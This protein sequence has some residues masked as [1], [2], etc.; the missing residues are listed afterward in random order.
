LPEGD[1]ERSIAYHNM[2]NLESAYFPGNDTLDLAMDY[3]KRAIKLR[4]GAGDIASSLLANSYLCMSRVHYLRAQYEDAFNL[5]AQSEALYVRTAG[6][7]THFMGHVHYAY[8]NI[9]FAQKRWVSAKRSY[10]TS[11][12]IGL[13]TAPIHPIT[14]AAYY[15]LG[16]VELELKN[17]DKSKS[18]LDK[19]MSIAQLRSP[20][21]DDGTM[22][23]IL[24]K[25]SVVLED[26]TVGSYAAEAISMR[27]RAELARRKLTGNGEGGLVFTIDEEGNADANETEDSYDALVPGYFR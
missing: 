24:W 7:N 6:A 10:D 14:A 5:L 16:C 19:A 1:I 18:Y 21:R 9:D 20:N 12:K 22:A 23:R 11:L 15:S 26:D 8:G 27:T 17:H 4:E 3:F 2:G 13:S 25:T